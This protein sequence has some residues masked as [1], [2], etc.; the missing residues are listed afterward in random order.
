MWN[1]TNK[2]NRLLNTENKLVARGDGGGGMGKMVKGSG[3][4]KL[5]FME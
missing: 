5:L 1:L 2:T 3:R 4:Y